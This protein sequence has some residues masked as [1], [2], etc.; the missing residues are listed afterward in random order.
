MADTI[1]VSVEEF[2]GDAAGFLAQVLQT[3]QTVVVE[4]AIGEQVEVRPAHPTHRRRVRT[5]EDHEAFLSAMGSWCDVDT[6]EFMRKVY[7]SRDLPPR[8]QVEL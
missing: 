8:P 6:D 5:P 1:H 3:Q 4:N 2:V 7:E